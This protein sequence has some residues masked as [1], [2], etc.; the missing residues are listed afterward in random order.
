MHS[1]RHT[2]RTRST[3]KQVLFSF[4]FPPP[5]FC[6]RIVDVRSGDMTFCQSRSNESRSV[7]PFRVSSFFFFYPFSL[8]SISVSILSL[9][10]FQ[11][12]SAMINR[13]TRL[14]RSRAA[15]VVVFTEALHS[16][17]KRLSFHGN[18]VT[19]WHLSTLM[20]TCR[21]G[22]VRRDAAYELGE[23]KTH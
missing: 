22:T 21:R 6:S 20:P 14:A 15:A 9:S 19:L 12:A 10:L 5:L 1:L 17:E 18:A 16:R 8:S 11:F 7:F 13:D 23:R 2:F 4:P 3:D